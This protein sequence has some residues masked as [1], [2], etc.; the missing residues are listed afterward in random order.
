[1][2]AAR[3]DLVAS[4]CRRAR[5]APADHSNLARPRSARSRARARGERLADLDR[6]L[7][8]RGRT[9]HSCGYLAHN[10]GGSDV[11]PRVRSKAR[12]CPQDVRV[13]PLTDS[14][15]WDPIA[16]SRDTGT[17]AP[18]STV[19]D[20]PGTSTA[21]VLKDDRTLSLAASPPLLDTGL[22]HNGSSAPPMRPQA[23]PG[24]VIGALQAARHHEE[25]GARPRT[26]RAGSDPWRPP[27]RPARCRIRWPRSVHPPATAPDPARRSVH[28]RRPPSLPLRR[29]RMDETFSDPA[30]MPDPASGAAVPRPGDARTAVEL[31]RLTG[32][33]RRGAPAPTRTRPSSPRDAAS[34][35]RAAVAAAVTAPRVV[36]GRVRPSR[37]R[38]GDRPDRETPATETEAENLRGAPRPAS[39]RSS[40]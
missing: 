15:C 17:R 34:A 3:L 25:P 4:R 1:M 6:T 21:H 2:L 16:R 10:P 19:A 8:R 26:G 20:V 36:P 38:R 39:S 24:P 37:E 14:L 12:D 29:T 11:S 28:A 18:Q 13:D 35:R 32:M 31:G 27:P 33:A 7:H 30:G 5:R 40:S 23:R 22:F 9:L